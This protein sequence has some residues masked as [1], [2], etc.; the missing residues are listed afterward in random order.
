MTA[1]VSASA[2]LE[3]R[4]L[5]YRRSLALARLFIDIG[6]EYIS[7][8]ELEIAIKGHIG[9]SSKTVRS[10]CELMIQFELI[11]PDKSRLDFFKVNPKEDFSAA[12]NKTQE[13][14]T[15]DARNEPTL[16]MRFKTSG[17]KSNGQTIPA[18][19]MQS[20]K[21]LVNLAKRGAKQTCSFKGYKTSWKFFVERC[22]ALGLDVC[23]VLDAFINSFL[24][25]ADES[26]DLVSTPINVGLSTLI[27]NLFLPYVVQKPRRRRRL[28]SYE[29]E[30]C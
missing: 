3:K 23:Y 20:S 9:A 25:A 14:Q 1:G 6:K 12:S 26:R 29:E 4:S 10:Y 27:V 24:V 5:P 13:K 18:L 16:N 28:V 30:E 7:Q 8:R 17:T 21:T 19:E 11:E 2:L 22:R 15:V